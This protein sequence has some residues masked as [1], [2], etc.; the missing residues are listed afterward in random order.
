[1]IYSNEQERNLI[2]LLGDFEILKAEYNFHTT[3]QKPEDIQ[4]AKTRLEF[5][6]QDLLTQKKLTQRAE[7]LFKE[8]VIS[9]QEYELSL[10]DLK[11]KEIQIDIAEA[12]YLS[13]STGDKPEMAALIK[14]KID[15]L[16]NQISQVKNRLNFFTVTSPVSGMVVSNRGI[17]NNEIVINIADTSSLVLLVP[18][19]LKELPYIKHDQEV[20]IGR[21]GIKVIGRILTIDNVVQTIDFKQALFATVV[22]EGNSD[23]IPGSFAEATIQ[24]GELSL[25]E[26]LKRI[27]NITF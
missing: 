11:L 25:V 7:N 9:D 3:G 24:S 4:Q 13:V 1:M 27:F 26:Y 8:A 5:V 16:S 12:H 14:A 10:N 15:A 19:E 2:Q 21:N 20:V 6:R 18:F 23:L 17:D 22:I